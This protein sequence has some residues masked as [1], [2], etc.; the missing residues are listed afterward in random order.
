MSIPV[1]WVK[2]WP[3]DDIL[4]FRILSGLVI[5]W[6]YLLLFRRKKL[7]QDRAYFRAL[8]K[9]SKRRAIAL[10]VFASVC[11]FGNWYTY[12]YAVNHI[13][14][15]SAAFAYMICP[16][17]TTFSAFILLKEQ[18]S[19]IKWTALGIALLSVSLLASGSLIDG[20]W[21]LAI[22]ALYAF[23]L[24]SQRVLQGFDKLN[25]LAVQ[26]LICSFFVLPILVIQGHP[27]PESPQFWGAIIVIAVVFTI[28]PLFLSMYALT[29]I[30]SSTT[31][32]L[33]Y[34]N[35]II[36][37]LLAL[38]YFK[39]AVDPHK[40]LAYGFLLVAIVLFNSSTLKKLRIADRS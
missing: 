39:E 28:V 35:P 27:L 36:A 18:L 30:S 14:V 6:L 33:L 38:F 23:Y 17:I 20:L 31:G 16:L 2:G 24:I 21:S 37:F 10:T 3:A 1:R 32:V 40:Y 26:L 15:Q 29:R 19:P 25:T 12:I 34:I 4:N 22:A 5:L 13:S 7:V 9:A 8:P 11:I